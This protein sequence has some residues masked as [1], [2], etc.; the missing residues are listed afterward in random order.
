MFI[1]LKNTSPYFSNGQRLS[2]E[3]PLFPTDF[4]TVFVIYHSL[5]RV[6]GQMAVPALKVQG[7]AGTLL[8][9]LLWGWGPRGLQ[10]HFSLESVSGSGSTVLMQRF[11][12]CFGDRS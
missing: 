6:T 12:L 3:E 9:V 10:K 1:A 2:T 11:A 5:Y 8:F 7:G 4:S